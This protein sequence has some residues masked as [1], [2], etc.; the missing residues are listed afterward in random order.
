MQTYALQNFMLSMDVKSS[1]DGLKTGIGDI[2]SSV[3]SLKS[4]EGKTFTKGATGSFGTDADVALASAKSELNAKM[5]YVKSGF[6]QF[7][8]NF[9][10]SGGSCS[11]PVFN[12]GSI[13]GVEVKRDLNDWCSQLSV[14]S[15]AF[16]FFAAVVAF[17]IVLGGND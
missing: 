13:K 17:R 14:L 12:Y 3:D 15:T 4:G 16:G 11:L 9:G 2:K 7:L 10:G 1:V 5:A 8:P 6:N